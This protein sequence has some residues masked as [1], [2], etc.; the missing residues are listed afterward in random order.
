MAAVAP[1]ENDDEPPMASAD[2]SSKFKHLFPL[3]VS[4]LSSVEPVSR[5]RSR[6]V[7]TQS[8]TE[9]SL[10]GS[11]AKNKRTSNV[12]DMNEHLGR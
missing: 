7:S 10:A 3:P 2:F 6:W 1:D 8:V 5:L 12:S 9:H 11:F 4:M